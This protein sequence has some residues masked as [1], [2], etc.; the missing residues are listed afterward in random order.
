MMIALTGYGQ[1]EDFDR[2]RDA[3]FDHHFVK[4][5]DLKTI[6]NAIDEGLSDEAKSRGAAHAGVG[7]HGAAKHPRKREPGERAEPRAMEARSGDLHGSGL[8]SATKPVFAGDTEMA[9]RMRALDWASTPLGPT[10]TWSPALLAAVSI[11]LDCAFPILVWWGP[12]LV[13]LYNDEYAS[14][15]GPSKHPRALGQP[16]RKFGR[17]SGTSS[18]RCPR[19]SW[20][21]AKPHARATWSCT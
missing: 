11:G 4:P 18:G 1:A 6:Q 5:A 16:V 12:E 8:A 10:E 2:S 17:R 20:S 13:M 14:M 19:R 3:G 9:R 15:L 7:Q 21:T